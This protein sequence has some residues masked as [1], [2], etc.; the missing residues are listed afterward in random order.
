LP[1]CGKK[2]E[3]ITFGAIP[4]GSAALIYIAREQGFLE[5]NGVRVT[6]TD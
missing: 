2:L 5:E 3:S 4:S 6:V 1:S